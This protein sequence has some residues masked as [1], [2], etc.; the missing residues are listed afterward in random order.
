MVSS[1]GIFV[2][3]REFDVERHQ[4]QIRIL[5]YDFLGK[6]ERVLY[7]ILIDGEFFQNWNKEPRQIVG[8]RF[9][10]R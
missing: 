2:N 1:K 9:D 8:T 4:V 7:S 6:R 10:G 5:S 3:I